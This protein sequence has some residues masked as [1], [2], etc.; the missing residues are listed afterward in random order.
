LLALIP[1]AA[2]VW[3]TVSRG[4]MVALASVLVVAMVYAAWRRQWA[5][6]GR[7]AGAVAVSVGLAFGLLYLG[8]HYVAQKKSTQ[9][10]DAISNF[11][12]QTVNISNGES[13]EGRT[14]TRELANKAFE[15]HPVL[16]LGPGGFGAYAAAQMP[17]RFGSG[18]AIVN[19]E[20]FELLA[21]TGLL[22]FLSLLAFVGWLFWLA[23]RAVKSSRL[24]YV[25]TY[26]PMLALVG[27]AL[28]Y[29]TFSTLYITHVWVTIGLLA[30]LTMSLQ[31]AH[32]RNKRTRT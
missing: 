15:A 32:P 24:D 30:G 29:Q 20:T 16:G 19:N 13:A 28:Q 23:V 1:V 31:S 3:L 17:A 6:A 26:G 11:S 22:G 27:I 14:V 5:G 18:T 12:Q 4:A 7:L 9:T 8:T 2:I 25:G 21:E 10:T